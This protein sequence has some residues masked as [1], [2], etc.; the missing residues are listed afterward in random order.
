MVCQLNFDFS[1]YIYIYIVLEFVKDWIKFKNNI[2]RTIFYTIIHA[3]INVGKYLYDALVLP[4]NTNVNFKVN[5]K[6]NS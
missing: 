5:H 2:D 3:K 1:R 6:E 4:L